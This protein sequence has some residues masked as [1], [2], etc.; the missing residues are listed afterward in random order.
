MLKIFFKSSRILTAF[1]GSI[2]SRSST[3]I[4]I[5]SYEF[6]E[7]SLISIARSESCS[8]SSLIEL[9]PS[10]NNSSVTSPAFDPPTTVAPTLK[11]P[12]KIFPVTFFILLF[13]MRF[14]LPL[15]IHLLSG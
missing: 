11:A 15:I 12:L 6:E 2:L 8:L 14:Y 10:P 7:L 9:F 4:I 13:W 1:S 3:Y 5:F